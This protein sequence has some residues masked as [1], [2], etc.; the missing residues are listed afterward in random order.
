MNRSVW[1]AVAAVLLAAVLAFGV[2]AY[3]GASG[4]SVQRSHPRSM[5]R[6]R[7]L[8]RHETIV[9]GSTATYRVRIR[10]FRF[11]AEVGLRV[12]HG[13]PSGASVRFSRRLTSKS[14]SILVIHTSARTQPGTYLLRVRARHGRLR[15]TVSVILTVE[16]QSPAG[17]A[18]SASVP[19]LTLGGG[20][21]DPLEPGVPQPVNV[22]IGNPN[23]LPLDLGHLT[24]TISSIS[25]PQ[26]TDVLPC[27]LA[28]FAVQQYSGQYPLVI[29]PSST[30]SL[31]AL[32]VPVTDWPQVELLDAPRNQ[33]GCQRA[34]L[35]LLYMATATLG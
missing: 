20:A 30:R 8:P 22:T 15:K 5:F 32:G 29:P 13:L 4:G 26:S 28:D 31:Q 35:T 6:L 23:A 21:A 2:V 16:P 1:R 3:A 24:V 9:A 12:T 34:S 10:R 25:A 19:P 17:G 33:D 14:R 7:V 18:T 27:S 11:G